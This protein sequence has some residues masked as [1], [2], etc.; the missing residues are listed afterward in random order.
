MMRRQN[1]AAAAVTF[2][3]LIVVAAFVGALAFALGGESRSSPF[4]SPDDG[5]YRGSEPPGTNRLPEFALRTYDGGPVRSH[6]LRG[7]VVLLTFLDS[8]CT[9]ACPILASQIA[10]AL[11][12]L[13]AHE[14]RKVVAVAITTDPAEDTRQSVRTF[15]EKQRA[16]GKILYLTRPAGEIRALWKRFKIASSEESGADTLHSA[17]LRIYD[18]DLVW[19]ATLHAGVDLTPENL[20]HD[21][22]V[23]LGESR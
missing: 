5:P 19:A 16:L 8:Q 10:Q 7:K 2:G 22:R 23:A 17:P 14:R 15:L 20:A 18:G 4:S 9:E 21:V 12:R 3:A 6:E 13:P 11:N 1:L